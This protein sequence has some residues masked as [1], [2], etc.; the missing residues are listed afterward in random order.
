M[1]NCSTEKE[2]EEAFTIFDSKADKF[3][4]RDELEEVL[5]RMGEELS[6]D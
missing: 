1:I 6:G 2:I 5:N 4:T 3:I